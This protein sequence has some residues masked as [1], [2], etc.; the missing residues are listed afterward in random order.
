MQTAC[1]FESHAIFHKTA[2][3]QEAACHCKPHNTPFI[4]VVKRATNSTSAILIATTKLKQH[5]TAH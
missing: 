4:I 3:A 5:Y 2:A 1:Q